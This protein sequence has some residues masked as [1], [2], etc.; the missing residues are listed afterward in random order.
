MK[1]LA[2]YLQR[3]GHALET[4]S[5]WYKANGHDVD[6]IRLPFGKAKQWKIAAGIKKNYDVV[7]TAEPNA[8]LGLL[9]A[10]GHFGKVIFWRIDFI[11]TKFFGAYWLGDTILRYFT[12]IWSIVPTTR[13][14]E[15]FVP[16]L[17]AEEEFVT[18]RTA[19][20]N[21]AISSGPTVIPLPR[22]IEGV[23]ILSTHWSD[24]RTDQELREYF[25]TAKIG[26]ALYNTTQKYKKYSDPSRAKKYL[27][28]GL[29]VI[30][31]GPAPFFKEIQQEFA[32]IHTAPDMYHLKAAITFCLE[33]FDAMSD[34]AYQLAYKYLVSERWIGL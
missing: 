21:L 11:P 8:A 27:A 9:T 1:I 20:T 19:R 14:K 30:G 7:I 28:C 16:Y 18:P 29:P 2:L 17:L 13:E 12:E 25:A 26:L 6:V 4:V 23:K 32:G 3:P 31:T 15:R 33:N 5:N 34:K 22:S 10:R 24:E